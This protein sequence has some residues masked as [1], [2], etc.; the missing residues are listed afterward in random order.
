[1]NNE[2]T[3]KPE[4][5]VTL[6]NSG[7]EDVNEA[8]SWVVRKL[9]TDLAGAEMLKINVE[10]SMITSFDPHDTWHFVWAASVGGVFNEAPD[11]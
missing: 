3:V 2:T 6:T 11:E 1:M 4:R 5:H 10:Q 8:L 7:F 9:D